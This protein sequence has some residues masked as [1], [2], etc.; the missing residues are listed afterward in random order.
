[1]EMNARAGRKPTRKVKS[2]KTRSVSVEKA[3]KVKGGP[4]MGPWRKS[5]IQQS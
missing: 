2:L 3:K 1:M 4:T 5:L